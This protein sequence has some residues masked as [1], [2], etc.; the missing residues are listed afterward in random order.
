M[1]TSELI[2]SF[3]MYECTRAS[4]LD[5]LSFWA[6]TAIRRDDEAMPT[7]PVMITIV[8]PSSVTGVKSPY[9][10]VKNVT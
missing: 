6:R 4:A 1:I 8:R 3:E 10:M 5:N 9:P 2:A 7:R